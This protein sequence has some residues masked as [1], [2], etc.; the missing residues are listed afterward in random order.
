MRS[1]AHLAAYRNVSAEPSFR[2][3]WNSARYHTNWAKEALVAG[4]DPVLFGSTDTSLDPR[5]LNDDDPWLKTYEGPL[6]G[7]RPLVLMGETPY[8]WTDFLRSKGYS[9]PEPISRA[10]GQREDGV[11][12][13][14]GAAVPKPLAYPAEHDDTNFLVDRCMDYIRD[15][16]GRFI[17]HLSI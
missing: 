14:D 16:K 12:Y 5:A 4:Y 15:A 9:V 3:Q 6:P 7:I 8:P 13:E 11:D 17:A 10:Y 2:H 1:V